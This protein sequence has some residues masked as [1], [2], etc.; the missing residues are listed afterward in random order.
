MCTVHSRRHGPVP[1]C[2]L[3]KY[4]PSSCARTMMYGAQTMMHSARTMKHSARRMKHSERTVE[5]MQPDRP[6]T[7]H[8]VT[9]R[10]YRSLLLVLELVKA[11]I[12][13]HTPAHACC[14]VT[15]I[16]PAFPGH[17]R[18]ITSPESAKCH[19]H[20]AGKRNMANAA[21]VGAALVDLQVVDDLHRAHLAD[22][23]AG[24]GRV[25]GKASGGR[26]VGCVEVWGRVDRC[27]GR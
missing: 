12:E 22:E 16:S 23:V 15:A 13:R 7:S 24:R 2:R 20:P 5:H 17:L 6:R 27:E 3:Y 4:R 19:V 25:F 8:V 1:C 18:R 14:G 26:R 21:T 11:P 10:V 9:I